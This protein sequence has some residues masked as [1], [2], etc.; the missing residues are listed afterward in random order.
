MR[1]SWT[2][3]AKSADTWRTWDRRC[4]AACC[5]CAPGPAFA[6][7]QVFCRKVI[8]AICDL[9][10]SGAWFGRKKFAEKFDSFA[11]ACDVTTVNSQFAIYDIAS[12]RRASAV[13]DDE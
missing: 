1:G 7:V 3:S 6:C 4:E 9:C 10:D 2:C 8:G 13:S 12:R 5:A 11:G